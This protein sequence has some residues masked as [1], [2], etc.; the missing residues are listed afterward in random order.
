MIVIEVAFALVLLMLAA[1]CAFGFLA[2]FEPNDPAI[3]MRW[4]IG[5][6]FVGFACL[7]GAAWLLFSSIR[8]TS[9]R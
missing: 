9:G 2:T 6:G 7:G 5:Y 3:A 8:R 4:R 1:F